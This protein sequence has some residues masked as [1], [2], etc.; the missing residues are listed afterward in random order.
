MT[1][2]RR[3]FIKQT[4]AL[5]A[6]GLVGSLGQWG[7]RAASAQTPSDYKALVCIF[8]FGGNDSNNMVIPYDNYGSYSAVRNAASNINIPQDKLLK[9]MPPSAGAAYGLHPSL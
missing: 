6:A 5:T 9:I 3:G 1:T 8:L 2:S 4:G 7:I